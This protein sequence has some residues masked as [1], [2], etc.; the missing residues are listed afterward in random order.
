MAGSGAAAAAEQ[1]A[2]GGGVLV[3]HGHA[4]HKKTF[5]KPTYCHHCGDMLWGLIQ[6]GFVCEVCNFIVHERCC[7]IVI[8]PCSCIAASLVKNPVGH[9]W[10]EIIHQKRKFCNVCRK[11]LDDCDSIHCEICEYYVHVECQD[12]AVPDCKENATYV[13][14][15][16]VEEVVHTHQWREGNLPS[17]SKCEYCRKTCSNTECLSGFRCEWCRM[18]C[19]AA[20]HVNVESDCTFGMLGPIYLPPHAV[21]IP[22]T[23][24]PME[25]II[26]V[27]VRRKEITLSLSNGAGRAG[28]VSN[29][30]HRFS[31]VSS[32]YQTLRHKPPRRRARSTSEEFSSGE[33]SR[34][35]ELE[36]NTQTH[37]SSSKEK[38]DKQN[39]KEEERDEEV[40]KV[41]DGNNSLRRRIFR[42][43]V[44]SRQASLN[45]LLVHALRAFHIT[46][47][48]GQFY[49]TDLYSP[50]EAV[51]RDPNPVLALNRKE[52]KRPA[53]FLRFKDREN[54]KGEVRVYPGKLQVSQAFCT[55]PVDSNTTIADLIREALYRFDVEYK[56]DDVRCLEVLL[57]RGV[58]ERVL[59]WSER[60]WYIMKSLGRDSIRQMELC[61]FYLQLKQDP[62]G[63]N[64]ALF[65]GNL[66]PN[67]V[68]N[69]YK[70]QLTDLLGKENKFSKIG[71]I[72]YEYGSMVVTFE[73]AE[74]AVRALY[75][76]RE[77][78]LEEK[79]NLLV[80]LLPN[81]EPSMIPADVHPLL[82]FVNV[83][84][85]GRQ[86][87]ELISNFRRLLN[88]YQVFDLDIGGPLP[89]LYV[90][91][92]I[93]KYKILVCGGDGTIGWVLQ[94]LDNV[95]QDSQCSSPACAIVPLGTG[96]DLARVLRWGAGYADGED[97][98]NL[99]K[100]VI[101]AEEILLDR[102]TV[103]LHPE[104]KSEKPE[105][106]LKQVNSTG[107]KRQ[108][109]SKL[110]VTNEQI[111]K[112]GSTSEDNS[113]I[114]VMNNYF[115]IGIDA[116]LCLDFHNAR[117]ENPGKFISRL[118]NKSVYV[119]IGLRR[120]VGQGKVYRDLHKLVQLE[121]DF[122]RVNLP[123]VE[124]I[125]VLNILSW[126][127][128]AN[129]WGLEKDQHFSKPTHFDGLLEVVGVTGVVHL[130]QIQ[131]GLRSAMRI[132][133]GKHIRIH[134]NADIPVQVDGEPWIQSPCEVVILKSALKA[135]MLKKKKFKRRPTEPIL[136]P[137]QVAA[138]SAAGGS[139]CPPE[140][141]QD[142]SANGEEGPTAS[143]P[144]PLTDDPPPQPSPAPQHH[145]QT[146]ATPF[147]QNSA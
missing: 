51:L 96:N 92:N 55:V 141:A 76:L 107:K 87:M 109:L 140:A 20:C 116:D 81:I 115:G 38:Q 54:D 89:G 61:R 83:K 127:S 111:K 30:R 11:R 122:K 114:L 135:T 71:P 16:E 8:S 70:N 15:K 86:G 22:R 31:F 143:R 63:P 21:S 3:A 126:G 9:C 91:R 72:Y 147:D 5:H 34:Y 103:V 138:G 80:M 108:K 2:A 137:P 56:C 47:D 79:Q 88:P 105:D 48:P 52:G 45:Q 33:A 67:L 74:T 68:E 134:L 129:P 28:S 44:V 99:L 50:E 1:A 117:E 75:I 12:F 4:F 84:S 66:P 36:E 41:F 101:E 65:L 62:H 97:P 53:V 112:A 40:I 121:V 24:V 18:T 128:G 35:R 102:W 78:R 25:S 90:F 120:M 124:G 6:Q 95:G 27:Q 60:P 125:I 37:S 85:G 13:P 14:G 113:Q 144:T 119:K 32:F 142:F 49:L 57:D 82:V 146:Q 58:T 118:H 29:L 7:K 77:A 46:K 104:E 17:G 106:S 26:G 131:S 23:E 42:I 98:L 73:D 64:V 139:A 94:C 100:D 132:A 69:A 110:K 123:Q 10:S 39:K 59:S 130:G 136:E 145:Q 43:V 93:P 133:Q 19:H